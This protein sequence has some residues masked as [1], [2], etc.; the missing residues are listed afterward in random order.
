MAEIRRNYDVMPP[1][2][3]IWLG[4]DLQKPFKDQVLLS[5]SSVAPRSPRR[6]L[7]QNLWAKLV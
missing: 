4:V 3:S 5:V 7:Q 6:V 1:D 2:P